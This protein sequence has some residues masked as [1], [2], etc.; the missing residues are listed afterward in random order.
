MELGEKNRYYLKKEY[1]DLVRSIL[2]NFE[3]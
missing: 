3:T 1:E 2:V